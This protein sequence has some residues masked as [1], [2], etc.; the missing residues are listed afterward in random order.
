M[1]TS[2]VEGPIYWGPGGE[3]GPFA[4]Q[5]AGEW[6]G[7]PDFGHVLRYFRK[8]AKLTAKA[9]GI[10]YGEAVNPDGS[11]IT[12]RQILRMELENQVPVDM[13]RRKLI[14]RLLNI[15]PGLFGLAVLEDIVL[16]P[17][18]Q[19][20]GAVMA[21]GQTTLQKVV[22]DTTRYQNNIRALWVLHDTSQAQGA[23]DQINADIRDLE[24]LEEQARGD[25]L[26]HIRE[27]LFSYHILAANVVRD[28]RKFSL[29]HHHANQA[30]RVA[31]GM[32]DTD[33]VATALYTRG[34]TYLEW[35]MFGTLARGV[36]QVQRDKI[37][38][39]IRDFEHAKK[40]PEEGEKGIHPQLLGRIAVHLSRAL[41]ILKVSDGE[42]A[43]AFS[44]TLLDSAAD[45][46]DRQRIDDPYTLS[47][48]TGTRRNFTKGGY[49]STRAAGLSI[50]GMQGAA[51]QELN[52]LET[53]Q[54]GAL[55]QDL[56]RHYA[57]LDLIAANIF[58]GLEEFEEATKRARRALIASQDINSVTNLTNV[59]DIHGRLLN[60]PYRAEQ[61]V[62]ELGDMV[63]ET[64]T[65]RI[66]QEE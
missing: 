37:A 4:E 38:C 39:A 64:L 48:V 51:L 58:M 41:A 31:K 8:K 13:N 59:V 66:K 43:L 25:L 56:T 45:V 46:I 63:R 62:K 34:C 32:N 35:G 24:S 57:W 7:W 12:E 2:I 19:V 61:D 9:F 5:K 44:I 11:P 50:A 54:Q 1:V 15:P 65:I 53:L 16:K 18:P 47:L 22:A 10:T 14:A 33:L 17:H 52:T 55:R 29:S 21:T 6:A 60:S 30:V 3:Y 42:K 36:F 23:L 20:A 49:H 40:T 26:Y 28:Q 27:L